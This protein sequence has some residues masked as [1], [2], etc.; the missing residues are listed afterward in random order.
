MANTAGCRGVKFKRGKVKI[1]GR[2]G[3]GIE[4]TISSEVKKGC[5]FSKQN[6]AVHFSV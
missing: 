3:Q 1:A 2:G 4:S 5:Y 6:F